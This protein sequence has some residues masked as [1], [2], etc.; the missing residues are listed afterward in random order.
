[1]RIGRGPNATECAQAQMYTP[2]ALKHEALTRT[3]A[4][5]VSLLRSSPANIRRL[6]ISGKLPTGLRITPLKIKIMLKIRWPKTSGKLPIRLR[7]PP[8]KIKT[9]LEP[10]PPKS[11]I[12]V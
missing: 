10:N 7:I 5:P 11:R 8:I 4:H 9:L 3:P 1:M 6:I 2:E 12:L